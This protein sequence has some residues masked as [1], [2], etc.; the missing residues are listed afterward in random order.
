MIIANKQY[1]VEY[2]ITPSIIT[3]SIINDKPKFI[4][5]DTETTGLHLKKDIPF[6]AAVCFNQKVYVFPA[7]S[8]MLSELPTWSSL[9]ETVYAHNTTFDMH[10]TANI[11]GDD[12]VL[13]VKNWGDTM[14]LCRLSF[15]AISVRD[16]GD[17]LALKSIAKKY[18]DSTSDKYEQEV[19]SWIRA[20]ESQDKKVL[21]ALL[22]FHGWS[23]KRYQQALDGKE[24]IPPE[25]IEVHNEWKR[26]YQ[27]PTYQDVPMD[28]MI[29]YLAVDVI[30]TA[31]IAE[32]AE[33]VVIKREQKEVMDREFANIPISF[34]TERVGIQTDQNYL[35]DSKYKLE[36]Y[37][38]DLKAKAFDLSNKTFK[39]GQHAI[40]KGI[41]QELLEETP[42]STDKAFLRKMERDGDE[43]SSIIMKWRTT[44]KWLSTYIE[45]IIENSEYDGRFYFQLGQFHPV[46]GRFSGDAQQFPRGSL[47]HH[48]TNEEL[49]YPRKVFIPSGQG[50]NSIYYLDFSQVEL[51][52]QS[53]YTLYFGGDLNLCRAYMPFR[54]QHYLTKEIYDHTT[55]KG[56]ERWSEMNGNKSAW[57]MENGEPWTPTDVH[58]QTTLKA[59][60][61]LKIDPS[62][63]SE[64]EFKS[65]RNVGKMFNFMRNYGGGYQKASDAL[66]ISLDEAKALADGYTD[67]FPK[68]IEYQN[69]VVDTM[70]KK[71]YVQNIYG[72]RY[73]I[74][75]SRRF[76]KCGNYLIQGTCADDLKEKLIVVD[77]Y[78]KSNN[79]K[80]RLILYVHDEI[81][82]EVYSGEEHIIREIKNIME[83]TPKINVP[84]IVEIEKT[85]TSWAEKRG[86]EHV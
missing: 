78:L 46:S 75:D 53:H 37:I 40:I 25:V 29:P 18:I 4:T 54:C 11:I 48:E 20:K 44:E 69:K 21:I 6:L 42:K 16:G 12:K 77:N 61:K 80:S 47:M 30:L 62:T 28:I 45:R 84:I 22:K 73:Y 17:S 71:G 13:Q 26:T 72:R 66:E 8:E 74:S 50:Y 7:N 23:L 59:L 38:E 34:K 57:L 64:K 81:Q 43:L 32:R 33:S 79:Y 67:S 14:A 27:K 82:I 68:V 63:L 55:L 56:L 19:K 35:F 15:E 36:Q 49:F 39:S 2:V 1:K 60:E 83:Y 24:D 31:N 58:T 5:Y 51:R 85:T 86:V 76:Y 3:E 52:V 10:M 70:R 41:Y 9:V 65:W